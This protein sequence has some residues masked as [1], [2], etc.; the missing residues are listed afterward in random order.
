MCLDVQERLARL[1]TD[2]NLKKSNATSAGVSSKKLICSRLCFLSFLPFIFKWSSGSQNLPSELRLDVININWV[3][4][5]GYPK[6]RATYHPDSWVWNHRNLLAVRVLQTATL[7]CHPEQQWNG[8]T[9]LRVCPSHLVR[10]ESILSSLKW[11]ELALFPLP[12]K[13]KKERTNQKTKDEHQKE[14]QIWIF[15]H[16]WPLCFPTPLMNDLDV[17]EI[18]PLKFVPIPHSLKYGV[19]K[20]KDNDQS[21]MQESEGNWQG[22]VARKGDRGKNEYRNGNKKD[23]N[24]C[25]LKILQ[26]WTFHPQ[27]LMHCADVLMKEHPLSL[28]PM[29]ISIVLCYEDQR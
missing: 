29:S 22:G 23:Q 12:L 19:I 20:R 10:V 6:R 25:C 3:I 5:R 11:V 7:H 26:R 1:F 9:L 15:L 28:P 14:D 2:I 16:G 13:M 18:L 21:V 27:T 8:C 4:T 17:Q 24:D